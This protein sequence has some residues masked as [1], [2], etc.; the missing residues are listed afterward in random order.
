MSIELGES[1]DY[2]STTIANYESGERL[3]DFI[4]AYAIAQ[5]YHVEMEKLM[6]QTGRL[7][8]SN[9]LILFTCGEGQNMLQCKTDIKI[10]AGDQYNSIDLL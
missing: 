10:V 8:K 2:G 3:P 5:R 1:I 9:R 6:E 4:T 7:E